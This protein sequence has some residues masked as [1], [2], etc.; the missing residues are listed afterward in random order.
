MKFA[1]FTPVVSESAIGR[2]A[3][4][5]TRAL[6]E[7]DHDIYIIRT[8]N[9]R[10]QNEHVHDFGVEIIPWNNSA[11][12]RDILNRTDMPVYQIGNYYPFH[13]GCLEWI[14][15]AP[16]IVSLHDVF[17]GHLFW[18]W[19]ENKRKDAQRILEAWYDQ[20][21]ARRYFNLSK[22]DFILQTHDTA[23]LT[24]WICSMA[25]GII[26]HS[27]FKIDRIQRSCTGPIYISP[28]PYSIDNFYKSTHSIKNDTN[29]RDK[30]IL[31][32]FGHVNA[33]KR[34][35]SVL[36][37]LG[38][39]TILRQRIVYRVAGAVDEKSAAELSALAENLDVQ[40]KLYG[41]VNDAELN[42]LLSQADIIICLRYPCL[43]SASSSAIEAMLHG[44]PIIVTNSGFY[45]ELP[46]N[47]VCKIQIESEITSIVEA[48]KMLCTNVELRQSMGAH[49]R[50]FAENT[51]TADT[52]ALRLTE[53]TQATA[54]CEPIKKAAEYLIDML[55]QWH[56][57]PDL[58]NNE[59][60]FG[61]LR[62]FSS[63]DIA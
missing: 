10:D 15:N 58:I 61:P 53:I 13:R 39:D 41:Y 22:D 25:K 19:F 44:K 31:L 30:L 62:I 34:I 29:D 57:A 48:L 54:N 36:H 17:V 55:G 4:L 59:H 18:A 43:E 24:E 20:D 51:F 6:I 56:A 16:G 26:T 32:T 21:I 7:Q 9:T 33:N 23:P 52:Y 5:L 12:V 2:V 49:A 50:S 47:C 46:D 3:C 45:H 11:R 27:S 35:T 63:Q 37:A 38:S 28:L 40:M 42:T 1:M 8:E 60:N 14:H